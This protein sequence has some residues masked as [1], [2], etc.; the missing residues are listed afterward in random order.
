[1]VVV[2]RTSPHGDVFT[3]FLDLERVCSKLI[4][5][6][7]LDFMVRREMAC[8]K[9]DGCL[10]VVMVFIGIKEVRQTSK[11]IFRWQELEFSE[12]S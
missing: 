2:L 10:M 12:I 7:L 6:P 9:G 11:T 4:V 8:K 1:M 3:F 5:I